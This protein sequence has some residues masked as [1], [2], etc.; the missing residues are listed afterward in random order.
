MK[1]CTVLLCVLMLLLSGCTSKQKNLEKEKLVAINATSF[2]QQRK[3]HEFYILLD[4]ATKNRTTEESLSHDFDEITQLYGESLEMDAESV[5]AIVQGNQVLVNV[6]VRFAHGW[7]D[8]SYTIN[9]TSSVTDFKITASDKL[10]ENG[11]NEQQYVYKTSIAE[12]NAVFTKPNGSEHAPVVIMIHDKNALDK[13]STI[14]VNK[15]FRNLA[16]TLADAGIASI[17]YDRILM[18]VDM[19]DSLYLILEELEAILASITQLEGIDSQQVYLLGYGVGGYLLPWLAQSLDVK[20]I[21]ISSAPSDH[22]EEVLYQ[23]QMYLIQQDQ[24]LSASE[25]NIKEEETTAALQIIQSLT[26]PEDF[27]YDV[28]GYSPEFWLSLKE[29]H[30]ID[31]AK[32]LSMKMLITQ[33]SNDYQVDTNEYNAWM[34]GLKGKSDVTFKYYTNMNHLLSIKKTTSGLADQYTENEISKAYIMDLIA[35]I[36]ND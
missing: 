36:Q 34:N 7:M 32:L 17:R 9:K 33:G 11:Y 35:F 29:Y 20:G 14:G 13:N 15:V 26:K 18:D 6:P 8:F 23:E 2:F 30:A 25:K 5:Q 19:E 27:S 4:S 21:I 10:D 28:F 16:Y 22:L 1:K 12:A 31:Q 3:D 24:T